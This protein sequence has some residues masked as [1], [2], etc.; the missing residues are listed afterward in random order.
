MKSVECSK[1]MKLYKHEEVYAN[2]SNDAA[3]E[4]IAV[5]RKQLV[6]KCT[7]FVAKTN[8][9][10]DARRNASNKAYE[11]ITVTRCGCSRD[12]NTFSVYSSA[13]FT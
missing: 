3:R 9:S 6:F 13:I 12:P 5:E 8:A 4:S 1:H 11:S 7:V 2:L 10:R